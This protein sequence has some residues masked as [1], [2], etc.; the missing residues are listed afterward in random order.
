MM[1]MWTIM[2]VIMVAVVVTYGNELQSWQQLIAM[3]GD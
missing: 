1:A 2:A 3:A